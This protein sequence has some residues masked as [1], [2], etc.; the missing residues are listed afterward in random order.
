MS[1]LD[2]AFEGLPDSLQ[3]ACWQIL[4]Q[5]ERRIELWDGLGHRD[6]LQLLHL[7]EHMPEAELSAIEKALGCENIFA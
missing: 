1:A 2:S 7:L 5:P 6:G 3:R 4:A